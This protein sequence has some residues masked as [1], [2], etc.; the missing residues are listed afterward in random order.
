MEPWLT[1]LPRADGRLRAVI[2]SS[3][4]AIMEVDLERRALLW[5]RAA[6]RIYG[7]TRE[8]MRAARDGDR[9][10]LVA[11]CKRCATSRRDRRRRASRRRA[12]VLGQQPLQ[13]RE[14]PSWIASTAA[15]ASGRRVSMVVTRR[16]VRV[17]AGP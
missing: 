16:G 3:P 12:R 5:N 4:L 7:R 13:R 1:D 6:E 2:E 11:M 14:I 9:A 15:T 8:E 17:Q 10:A